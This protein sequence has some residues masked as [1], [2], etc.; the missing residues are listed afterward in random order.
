MSEK[1]HQG[2]S[3]DFWKNHPDVTHFIREIKLDLLL[4]KI[5][6]GADF[7]RCRDGPLLISVEI[8]GICEKPVGHRV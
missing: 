4:S 3:Q 2:V 1:F 7:R 5:T 6:D 8:R